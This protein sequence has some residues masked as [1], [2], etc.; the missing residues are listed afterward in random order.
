MGCLFGDRQGDPVVTRC[1][2]VTAS[3][4]CMN[5]AENGGEGVRFATEPWR[6]VYNF[7][8]VPEVTRL[9][10]NQEYGRGLRNNVL[11]KHWEH[12][13]LVTNG[14]GLQMEGLSRK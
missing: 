14:L 13:T 10:L 1:A 11:L 7:D 9:L 4:I 5:M 8:K 2:L 12:A 3:L 6:V